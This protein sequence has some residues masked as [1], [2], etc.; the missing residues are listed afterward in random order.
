MFN[1]A[2]KQ[3]SNQATKQP[4]NQSTNQPT[5]KR[6][7]GLVDNMQQKVSSSSD[8]IFRLPETE[9]EKI[10]FI[11]KRF[12]KLNVQEKAD[13]FFKLYDVSYENPDAETKDRILKEMETE[14]AF[15]EDY[16]TEMKDYIKDKAPPLGLRIEEFENRYPNKDKEYKGEDQIYHNFSVPRFLEYYIHY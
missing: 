9:E 13:K 15:T 3:P 10:T 14:L 6:S 12:P 2:T 16:A 11:K 8:T 7:A 4:S 5:N 1:N